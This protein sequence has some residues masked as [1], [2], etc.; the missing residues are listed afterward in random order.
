[1]KFRRIVS[2]LAAGAASVS[3]AGPALAQTTGG[4]QGQI[5][6]G[7]TQ[8]PVPDAVVI[9]TSPALHG[10]QTAVID[11]SGSFEI[12]LL[13]QGV[14]KLDVQREGYK[15]FSQPDLTLRLDKTLRIKLQLTPDSLQANLVIEYHRCRSR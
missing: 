4:L 14:Y 5:I 12:S 7:S 3:L 10:E 9:A 1:M 13:P 6:D 11:A 2:I 15:P 8:Q